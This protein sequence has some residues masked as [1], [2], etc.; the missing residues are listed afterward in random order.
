MANYPERKIVPVTI[1]ITGSSS[2]SQYPAYQPL[3][4]NQDKESKYLNLVVQLQSQLIEQQRQ[5]NLL[6]E[7]QKELQPQP[8]QQLQPAQLST[9]A[10]NQGGN[11]N[12]GGQGKGKKSKKKKKNSERVADN[13]MPFYEY[14]EFYE[15]MRTRNSHQQHGG[16]SGRGR[17]RGGR[18]GRRGSRGDG[19]SGRGS[20]RG[21]TSSGRNGRD[22]GRGMRFGSVREW[23]N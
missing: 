15:Y 20:G 7:Q 12:Q 11:V 10:E 16:R 8:Q 21:G 22:G 4:V 6:A 14:N 2:S 18:G 1:D 13:S 23:N 17:G 9:V 3:Q 19:R 5:L